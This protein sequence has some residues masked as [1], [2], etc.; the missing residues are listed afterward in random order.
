M[1]H[2]YYVV[3][4][5]TS[6]E[7]PFR[8]TPTSVLPNETDELS[9]TQ[10]PF[11]WTGFLGR[12]EAQWSQWGTHGPRGTLSESSVQLMWVGLWPVENRCAVVVIKQSCKQANRLIMSGASE[13][14]PIKTFFPPR[15]FAIFK[16]IFYGSCGESASIVME[17]LGFPVT[18]MWRQIIVKECL[19]WQHIPPPS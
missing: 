3:D 2:V 8:T 5:D 19:T 17:K 15:F 7:V 10:G 14:H 4:L 11:V 12:L 13:T 18:N 1:D 16:R 6:K 9:L